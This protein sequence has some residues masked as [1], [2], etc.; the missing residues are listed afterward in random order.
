[1]KTIRNLKVILI[2]LIGITS[3]G[4][5]PKHI[6]VP[7]PTPYYIEVKCSIPKVDCNKYKHTLDSQQEELKACIDEL[8][9][10]IK[11]CSD[12]ELK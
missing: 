4:C 9:A 3:V 11:V 6:N 5:A 10:T 12:E 7:V 2:T 8:R 1:M